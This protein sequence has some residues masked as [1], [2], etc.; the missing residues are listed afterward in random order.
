[1]FTS[2]DGSVIIFT[3]Y[4]MQFLAGREFQADRTLSERK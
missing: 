2:S 3:C 4:W 1:M